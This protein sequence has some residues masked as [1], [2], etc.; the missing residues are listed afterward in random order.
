MRA[1]SVFR[2]CLLVL[3]MFLW[4]LATWAD[5][6]HVAVAANFKKPFESLA[7]RFEKES[8]HILV[9]SSG[10][11]G[12]LFA[13]ISH[14][15]P[16][17]LFLSAD[18]VRPQ[19]L[20]EK[21]MAVPDSLFTYAKGQL[22]LWSPNPTLFANGSEALTNGRLQRIALGNYRSVP[23]GQAAR[24]TL[25][26]L[27]LWETY[28]GRMA[29]GENVGQV[30]AFVLSGN[31]DA[32]FVALSQILDHQGAPLSGSYWKVPSHLYTT[33]MQAAVHLNQPG[34]MEP[35]QSLIQFLRSPSILDSLEYLGY[36][37]P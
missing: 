28:T 20:Q 21:G 31:A 11:S 37:P 7:R 29:F 24:E 14:G 10:S 23:Y 32:G 19:R 6:I 22:V 34:T 13:Q 15:A 26:S 33:L 1:L 5:T 8:G 9:I 18:L 36:L 17:Q 2:S 25:I 3:C 12:K 35:T 4:P 16:F 30:L 27:G